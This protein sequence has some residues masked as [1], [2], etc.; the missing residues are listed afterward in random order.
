MGRTP[1]PWWW[2]ERQAYYATIDGVR[3]RLGED[4]KSADAEFHRLMAGRGRVVTPENITLA[5]VMAPFLEWSADNR[6]PLT[7]A[8]HIRLLNSFLAFVGPNREVQ[9]LIPHDVTRWLAENPQWGDGG[10]RAAIG[11]VKRALAWAVEEGL[12]KTSPLHAIK[13]PKVRVK[14][15][16]LVPGEVSGL[17]DA[18]ADPLFRELVEIS[19]ETGAR[20]EEIRTVAREHVFLDRGLWVFPEEEHKTGKK[21][22]RERIVYLTLRAVEITKRRLSLLKE[23]DRGPLFRN[24]FGRPWTRHSINCRFKRLRAKHPEL[25]AATTAYA[26]RKTFTTQ[27]LVNGLHPEEVRELIG[28]QDL[29]MLKHYAHMGE[30]QEHMKEAAERARNAKS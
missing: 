23:D 4:K 14:R 3:H 30:H 26:I 19:L 20:P 16:A 25:P 28:H 12:L 24:R 8:E 9:S 18:I 6:E 7:V 13:R 29:S 10:K 5:E 11:S 15:V 1:K 21:T 22:Q 27:A 2:D 17:L